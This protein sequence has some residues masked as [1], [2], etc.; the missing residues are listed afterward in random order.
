LWGLGGSSDSLHAFRAFVHGRL[1][2]DSQIN[3]WRRRL[4]QKETRP[5]EA[6]GATKPESSFSL[7][8][9]IKKTSVKKGGQGRL[10][11]EMKISSTPPSELG[12]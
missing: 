2:R 6:K 11:K 5:R 4:D 8:G 9:N 1:V 10:N 12:V 3:V 7:D